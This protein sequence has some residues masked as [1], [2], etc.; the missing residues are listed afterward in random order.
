MLYGANEAMVR[1]GPDM[2][3]EGRVRSRRAGRMRITHMQAHIEE[4][5]VYTKR[6]PNVDSI[7]APG[8]WRDTT[9]MRQLSGRSKWTAE[10]EASEILAR[11]S[12]RVTPCK[13]APSQQES[14]NQHRSP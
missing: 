6:V 7:M 2:R 4:R 5:L 11:E 12:L 13:F 10:V 3:A 9:R 14:A 1:A 8:L